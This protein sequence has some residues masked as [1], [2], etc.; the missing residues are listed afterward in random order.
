MTFATKANVIRLIKSGTVRWAGLR[1]TNGVK[2]FGWVR[3]KNE[4]NTLNLS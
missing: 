1:S 4:T 2:S 3:N